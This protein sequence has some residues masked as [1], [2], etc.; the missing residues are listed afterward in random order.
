MRNIIKY[1]IVGLSVFATVISCNKEDFLAPEQPPLF[2]WTD[3]A[4]FENATVAPYFYINAGGWA[5]VLGVSVFLDMGSSDLGA[6]D[7]QE[8][9]SPWDVYLYRKFRETAITSSGGGSRQYS[10]FRYCYRQITFCNDPLTFID[11]KGDGEIFPGVTKDD[12]TIKRIKAELLFFRARAY[13]YLVYQF[14]PPYNPGGDNSLKLLPYKPKFSG[15]PDDIRHTELGSSQDIYDLIVSDLTTAKELMPLSYDGEGKV[16]HYVICAAL[17]RIYFLIGKHAEARAECDEILNS[18]KYPLQ[19]DVMA[20]WNK[21]PGEPTASEVIMEYVPDPTVD[22]NE[23]EATI[24]NKT[25]ASA[26]NGGRGEDWD[27]CT[28][29]TYYMSNYFMKETGW[30]VDPPNDYSVG[31]VALQGDKRYNNTYI[32]LEGYIPKP[33]TMEEV[34]YK[35]HYQ[36]TF[37]NITWPQIWLDKYYRG[38]NGYTKRPLFR[39]AEFYLTRAAIDC[40][41][42]YGD[43]GEADLNTVRN[44][45]GLPSIHKSDYVTK[46]DWFNEIHRERM[47]ELGNEEGD[48]NRYLMSLR[49]PLGLGDRP[50]DGSQGDIVNPPYSKFYFRIPD[51]EINSNAAY[52]QGFT[53][54]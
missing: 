26:I 18:G 1:T 38:A 11:N 15:K 52:P 40:E 41:N 51:N 4:S 43:F 20:A 34:Y 54:E 12:E 17:A 32:R 14:C 6:W 3:L 5:D 36:T 27:M 39:S 29:V 33:D 28:W 16:N 24:I 19:A 21:L 10:V 44:R 30:M 23:Y 9:N 46:E 31:P 13:A 48:R 45:A 50:A 7:H 8:S 22:D 25:S 53:Q 49:L 42:D 2:P 37:Q 35:N 47:R